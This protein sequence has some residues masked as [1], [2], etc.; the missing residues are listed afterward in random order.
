MSVEATKIFPSQIAETETT[1]ERKLWLFSPAVDLSVFAGSVN[2]QDCKFDGKPLI[3]TL[4]CAPCRQ[5]EVL[6]KLPGLLQVVWAKENGIVES[7][8]KTNNRIKAANFVLK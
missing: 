6:P 7:H 3:L 2:I 1:G 4:I 5:A 8:K